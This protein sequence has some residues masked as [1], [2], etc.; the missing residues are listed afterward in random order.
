MLK[1]LPGESSG[2][3]PL[4]VYSP[5]RFFFRAGEQEV[6]KQALLGETDDDLAST[7]NISRSAVKKRWSAIYERVAAQDAELLP[8]AFD[9]N[10][11][12]RGAQ[13]KTSLAAVRAASSRRTSP[14]GTTIW[15][16]R[17]SLKRVN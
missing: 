6:L 3:S 12:K 5:P 14:G 1:L 13:K 7:L 17:A 2:L 11:L 15:D 4:F 9:D 8:S 16:K 10:S